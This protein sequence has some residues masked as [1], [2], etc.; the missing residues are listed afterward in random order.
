LASTRKKRVM[1][2]QNR[3]E[4]GMVFK[5][6]AQVLEVEDKGRWRRRTSTCPS[7]NIAHVWCC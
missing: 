5:E 6:E 4:M 1:L 7:R 2:L 3:R